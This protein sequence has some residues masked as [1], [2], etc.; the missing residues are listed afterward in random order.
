M[1]EP[2]LIGS[3]LVALLA[4]AILT[5]AW[6]A[7]ARKQRIGRRAQRDALRRTERMASRGTLSDG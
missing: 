6:L 3:A 2:V 7:T 5:A 1:T 4:L